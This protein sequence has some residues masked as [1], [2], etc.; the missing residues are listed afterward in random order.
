MKKVTLCFG[1]IALLLVGNAMASTEETKQTA[2]DDGLAWLAAT[3]TI[4]G[5]EGYWPYSNDGTLAATASAAL[6]FI[7]EGYLPGDASIY[8]AVVTRAVTYIFNRA[9]VDG[10]FGVEYAVYER[11]AEDYSNDGAPYDEGNDEAIFFEPGV[12]GRRVY[13]TGICVP[14]VY[15]L[16]EAFGNSTV[17]S[18]GSAAINGK[19]YAQAMQDLVDWFAWGQVEPNLGNYRG[20]WRYDANY[21]ESDNS[22]A[23]WGSLPLLY[24]ADWGLGVPQ[25]VF[26][27]L[28]LWVNYIQNGVSGG[29]GYTNP[30]NYVNVAKTGG[31]LLELAAI[32]APVGDA[33]VVAALGF[34]DSRW[35][36]GPSGTWYGNLN[37]PYAMWAVYKGLQVYGYLVD[38]DCGPEDIP[39]GYGMPAAPGG[40]SICFDAAPTASAAG[41]WYSHYCDYLVGI[42]NGDGSWSG[43]SHWYGPMA[44][45]WYINILN[46]VPVPHGPFQVALDI[47][48][49]SCPNPMNI[50]IFE[51]ENGALTKKGGVLP[52][53]IL[54]TDDFDV[55]DVD[56]SSLL[57][58]GVAPIRHHYE[59]VAAP[60]EG[61]E[62]CGCTTAGPDGNVDLTLKFRKSAIAQAMGTVYNGNMVPLTIT[63]MLNNGTELEGVD[64]VWIRSKEEEPPVPIGGN[65]V[66]LGEAVPNPF[67]PTTRISF[68]LPKEGVVELNVYDVRGRLL[69]RLVSGAVSA[70]EHVVKWDAKGVPS[71]TYFYRLQVGNFTETR[72]MILLK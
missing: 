17:I 1:L 21:S 72:K 46:A 52:V 67:N 5:A 8:D 15:A 38:F 41:D 29:S 61:D 48:P 26:D 3:Q 6:A 47:K 60:Y 35:N 55:H 32:G 24:A 4:S 65:N 2:I 9:V 18:V 42:Q 27:E 13:T 69:E 66:V 31:L 62:Q 50:K 49:T 45:G 40:L 30:S 70:G 16:G 57:L 36:N 23:Q 10:R 12:S 71:G 63:G 58:M 7:E 19:T 11:Y 64:C 37:H 14:V 44:T 51:K 53:A 56:V 54:G 59:D 34:I 28:E 20:G 33:R 22:T 68:Y 25:Y 43:Y 39:I